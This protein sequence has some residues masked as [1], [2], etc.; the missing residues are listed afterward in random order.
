MYDDS[1]R[2]VWYF[3]AGPMSSATTYS[4]AVLQFANGQTMGG[5][6]HP[7]GTP[8]TVATLDVQ[9]T[10]ANEATLTF[11]E[12]SAAGVNSAKAG[13]TRTTNVTTQ[14]PQVPFYIQP[15]GFAGFFSD[16]KTAHFAQ[17]GVTSDLHYS[18]YLDV[19]LRPLDN[20]PELEKTYTMTSG[21]ITLALQSNSVDSLATCTQSGSTTFSV[22]DLGSN[23]LFYLD[24][25][26]FERYSLV[27]DFGEGTLAFDTILTCTGPGGTFTTTAPG[28]NAGNKLRYEG[29]IVGD[30]V[31]GSGILQTSVGGVSSTHKYDWNFIG[32]R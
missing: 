5:P 28:F 21:S 1:G 10:A 24:A 27:I 2:P 30:T 32:I 17:S 8:A 9:F 22:S 23:H 31:K 26:V 14:L 6:Y 19:T 18:F 29:A 3:S 12:A 4:G 20:V 13:R 11:T 15:L 16:D 7:P 25:S